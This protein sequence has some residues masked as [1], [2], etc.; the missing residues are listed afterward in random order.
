MRY[1]IAILFL[2][3]CY[4]GNSQIKLG[5][6]LIQN[7]NPKGVSLILDSG[8]RFNYFDV[9]AAGDYW[10]LQGLWKVEFQRRYAAFRTQNA[11]NKATSGYAVNLY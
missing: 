8:F 9:R 11:S 6:Y 3:S 1:L 4:T 5:K 2:C 7:D 10:W